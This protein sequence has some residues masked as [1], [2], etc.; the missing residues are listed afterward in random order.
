MGGVS[1]GGAWPADRDVSDSDD[2]DGAEICVVDDDKTTN[3]NNDVDDDD[4]D[5]QS[6][7][8]GVTSPSQHDVA[9]AAYHAKS[10]YNHPLSPP[11]SSNDIYPSYKSQG[12]V[13]TYLVIIA[14]R[15][16]S[17]PD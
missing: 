15:A 11:R 12:S 6:R 17:S 3:D 13:V 10:A 4:D 2:D 7:R 9:L 14:I 8:P 16:T 5:D 1:G